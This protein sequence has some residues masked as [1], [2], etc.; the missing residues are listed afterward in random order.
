MR[1]KQNLNLY[2]LKVKPST[3]LPLKQE[4]EKHNGTTTLEIAVFNITFSFCRFQKLS[5][6]FISHN[7]PLVVSFFLIQFNIPFKIISL[8]ETSQWVGWAKREYP[9]KTT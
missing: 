7:G 2:K 1:T 6:L 5:Q 8:I 4:T 3:K 9:G